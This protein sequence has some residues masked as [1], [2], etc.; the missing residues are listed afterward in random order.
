[1]YKALALPEKFKNLNT[2]FYIA[3]ILNHPIILIKMPQI[4]PFKGIHYNPEKLKNILSLAAPPYDI[5]SAEIQEELYRKSPYNVVRL[6][7]GRIFPED[8][9]N[10]NRYTRASKDFSGWTM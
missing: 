2:I 9:E 10:N 7:L 8:N 1:M 5:I 3:K 6:T 4:L